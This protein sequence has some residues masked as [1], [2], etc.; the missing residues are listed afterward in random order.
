VGL[1]REVTALELGD[2][3]VVL[4]VASLQLGPTPVLG[5][6]QLGDTTSLLLRDVALSPL[7]RGSQ[8][9]FLPAPHGQDLVPVIALLLL[10]HR[11]V[12]LPLR[13]QL[14]RLLVA[15]R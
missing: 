10:G 5:R 14:H 1:L 3:R 8:L 15:R 9:F 6:L 11:L 13:R 7:L 4:L 12:G 2:A